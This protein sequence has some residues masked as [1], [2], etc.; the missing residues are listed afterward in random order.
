[1]SVKLKVRHT[2]GTAAGC[3]HRITPIS[4]LL[5]FGLAE[6][7]GVKRSFGEEGNTTKSGAA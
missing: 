5:G 2:P 6:P 7:G 3:F 1:M 4:T